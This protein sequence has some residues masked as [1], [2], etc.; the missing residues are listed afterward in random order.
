MRKN[1]IPDL[2]LI[3]QPNSTTFRHTPTTI[4]CMQF[5]TRLV[6]TRKESMKTTKINAF[7]QGT[8]CASKNT[9]EQTHS[10][11]EHNVHV[12]VIS[13]RKQFTEDTSAPLNTLINHTALDIT[14]NVRLISLRTVTKC[15]SH[16]SRLDS[17]SLPISG[18]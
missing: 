9:H 4:H 11:V 15:I 10:C 17:M 1:H 7:T 2:F 5:C 6:N 16:S 12:L 8:M 18:K 14:G 13:S 3:V